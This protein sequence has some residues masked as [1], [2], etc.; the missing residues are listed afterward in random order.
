MQVAVIHDWL[1]KRGGAENVLEQI[2]LLYPNAEIYSLVD[3]ADRERMPFL[4]GRKIH[5]SFVNKLPFAKNHFRKYLPFFPIAIESFDL[6]RYDLVISSSFAVAKGVIINPDQKHISYMHSPIRYAWDMQGEYSKTHKIMRGIAKPFVSF[7]MHKLRIW[8]AVSSLRID[9]I[10][11]NSEFVRRRINKCYN[12]DSKVIYPPVD[13]EFFAK[14]QKKIE[15]DFY[16]TACRHVGY[17]NLDLLV[18]AFNK[19]PDKKLYIAGEGPQTRKLKEM[20]KTNIVFL[21]NISRE[22][23][24]DNMQA[25]KAFLYAAIEDFGIVMV[26][27][28]AAGTPVIA[29]AKGGAVDII[30][31]AP[32]NKKVGLLFAEQTVAAISEA[33]AIFEKDQKKF[34]KSNVQ[35]RSRRFS[36]ELFMK[37]FLKICAS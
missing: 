29:Y 33:V 17:K 3:F 16:F 24:R 25:A 2:L 30:S 31:G 4:Q 32:S 21:G 18:K 15:G 12:L 8:D 13:V 11:T 35:A 10:V 19:M 26:E 20:A 5:T 22:K 36:C 37:E 34:T 1:D 28:L 23:L 9:Q 27:S 7:M 14:K 6:R